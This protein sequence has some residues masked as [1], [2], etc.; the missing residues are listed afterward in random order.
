MVE[1]GGA[2]AAGER[3]AQQQPAAAPHLEH[4]IAGLERQR[5]ED[6]PASK[7][8]HVLGPVHVAGPRA[9]GTARHPVGEPIH[10]GVFGQPGLAPGG[11]ILAL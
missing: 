6:G 7:V 1:P 11:E 4:V 3:I 8:M 10:E 9:G 2:S 5:L